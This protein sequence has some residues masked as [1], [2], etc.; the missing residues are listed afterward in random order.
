MNYIIKD[1]PQ[2][3][4]S[5]VYHTR[6]K[7]NGIVYKIN[8]TTAKDDEKND[9]AIS[10][11]K[12]DKY[13]DKL[14]IN[15][16]YSPIEGDEIQTS[17]EKQI[18]KYINL[19]DYVICG[20]NI[21]ADDIIPIENE[22]KDET[23]KLA[24]KFKKEQEDE[25][26]N[27]ILNG[28]NP[29]EAYNSLPTFFRYVKEDGKTYFEGCTLALTGVT[30]LKEDGKPVIH[31]DNPVVDNGLTEDAMNKIEK[32]AEDVAQ[33]AVDNYIAGLNLGYKIEIDVPQLT[34]K[35]VE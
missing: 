18:L 13:K 12:N 28:A 23:Y 6:P 27:R 1:E 31:I 14:F 4:S 30:P 10:F 3:N 34:A 19:Q 21:T 5:R 2:P 35:R 24:A 25:M 20:T 8:N 33:K 11:V 29:T 32:L 22:F 7:D 15:L 17:E 26:Y 16:K 9:A